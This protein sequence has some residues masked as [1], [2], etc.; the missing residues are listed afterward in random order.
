MAHIGL[1]QARR[2]NRLHNEALILSCTS[3][4]SFH[5]S[6]AAARTHS[7]HTW[8]MYV[9]HT[10]K[11]RVVEKHVRM[12]GI[13][14]PPSNVCHVAGCQKHWGLVVGS[15]DDEASSSTLGLGWGLSPEQPQ[16]YFLLLEHMGQ[17]SKGGIPDTG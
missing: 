15:D 1:A 4:L 6:H 12:R 8:R 9:T 17:G 11:P 10:H 5:W 14:L 7:T 2:T 13:D 3:R 16:P